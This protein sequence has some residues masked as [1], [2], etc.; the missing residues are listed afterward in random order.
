MLR[1]ITRRPGRSFWARAATS[2]PLSL[3]IAMSRM[4]TSGAALAQPERLLAVAGFADHRDAGLGL[5][6]RPHAAPDEA[7][8][9]S[10]QDAQ[11]RPPRAS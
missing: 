10:Q 11:A 5:E 2:M 6:Q 7:L 8:I 3:G 4:A 1:M 9:V